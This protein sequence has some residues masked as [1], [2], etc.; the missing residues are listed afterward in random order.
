MDEGREG[1]RE[2]GVSYKADDGWEAP[3]VMMA[4]QR[5]SAREE[6]RPQALLCV[7]RWGGTTRYLLQIHCRCAIPSSKRRLV[8]QRALSGGSQVPHQQQFC[9]NNRD[10]ERLAVSFFFFESPRPWNKNRWKSK[11]QK[12]C[13]RSRESEEQEQK[14]SLWPRD[15]LTD[16]VL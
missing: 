15:W 1:G 11:R 2:E 14:E 10:L 8:P 9:N 5:L 13:K 6:D 12:W 7:N 4:F 3:S 16:T